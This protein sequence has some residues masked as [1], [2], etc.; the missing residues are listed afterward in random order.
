MPYFVAQIWR[1]SYGSICSKGNYGFSTKE[2]VKQLHFPDTLPYKDLTLGTNQQPCE[3]HHGV[4]LIGETHDNPTPSKMTFDDLKEAFTAKA[5]NSF[6]LLQGRHQISSTSRIFS[7][8]NVNCTW[9]NHWHNPQCKVIIATTP[10]IIDW[11]LKLDG[12]RPSLSLEI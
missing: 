10:R 12:G 11:P 6:Y 7:S 5:W 4:Y 3:R 1:T 2:S 9:S 8:T